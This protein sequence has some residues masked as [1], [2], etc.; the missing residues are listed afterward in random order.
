MVTTLAGW[1]RQ[2]RPSPGPTSRSASLT[3]SPPQARA[4][5]RDFG[6]GEAVDLTMREPGINVGASGRYLFYTAHR[7]LRDVVIQ[8]SSRFQTTFE[9]SEAPVFSITGVRFTGSGYVESPAYSAEFRRSDREL[10]VGLTADAPRYDP[11]AEAKVTVT[12]RDR[13]GKPV[14]ATVVLRGL[15]EKLFAMG[16]AEPAD[17]LA[18]LYSSVPSGILTTYRSHREPIPFP[19][20]GDTTGGGADKALRD[21]FRDVVLFRQ[22]TT[23]QDGTAVVTFRVADDLTTWRVSASA[24]GEGLHRWRSVDRHPG[25]SPVLRGR[26]DRVRISRVRSALSSGSGHSVLR[27]QA[28]QPVTFTVDSDSL[29]IHM[30]GIEAKAFETASVPLPKLTTG[31]HA[32]TIKATTGSGATAR[33]DAA[34][35]TFTVVTSRLTHT[36]TAYVEAAIGTHPEGGDG[37]VEVIVTD[38]GAARYIPLLLDLAGADSARMERTLAASL[39]GSLLTERFH[40]G[41]AVPPGSFDAG[42]YQ[43]EDGVAILPYSS[44]SLSASAMAALVAPDIFDRERLATYLWAVADGAKSTRESR[45]IALAGLAGLHEPVLPSLRRSAADPDLTVRERLMLALGAAALGD[46]ATAREIGTALL[47]KYG[48]VTG[49]TA[50]LRVGDSAANITDATALMAMLAAADG[51]ALAGRLWSYV[52]ADPGSETTYSLHAVGFVTRFW[53]VPL[54]DRRPSAIRSMRSDRSSSCPP[55]RR[56]RSRS[57]TSSSSRSRW[58]RSPVRS[59]SRRAGTSR[60]PRPPSGRTRTSRSRGEISPSGAIGSGT[61]VTVDLTVALGP[62]APKGCHLVTDLVPSGLVAVGTLEGSINPD[63]DEVAAKDA[64]YPF[65]EFGQRAE[66][67]AEKDA[68]LGRPIHLR[69]FARVVT[70]GTYTWEPAMAESRTKTGRAAITKATGITIR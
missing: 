54:P 55:A 63:E 50:R 24:F 60:S 51:D 64:V 31:K 48:E 36:R 43:T 28:G 6:I 4:Y 47:A 21:D 69:Y 12:T 30:K 35:R 17:P 16:M 68:K 39:A 20:G 45:N 70:G 46:A 53:N 29:G 3:L 7:G 56:S 1:A 11:G 10:T 67:C 27:L 22:I 5:D 65:A 58:N 23:G 49:E 34:T 18:E 15:D 59:A 14:A 66:F 41:D 9:D 13:S 32:V 57:T 62:K 19:E 38:A 37:H 61:L 8:D 52:E 26:H 42:T 44:R 33:R 2:A 40:L 25:R